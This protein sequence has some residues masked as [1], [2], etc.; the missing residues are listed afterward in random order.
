[1][2]S[3]GHLIP[4]HRAVS[5]DSNAAGFNEQGTIVATAPS[6]A[7][8]LS[9]MLSD[10]MYSTGGCDKFKF[11][12]IVSRMPTQQIEA[13]LIASKRRS[14]HEIHQGYFSRINSTLSSSYGDLGTSSLSMSN[15]SRYPTTAMM[16]NSPPLMAAPTLFESTM[17]KISSYVRDFEAGK[18]FEFE[19]PG[20]PADP[21]QQEP[22]ER[23]SFGHA[24]SLS[25]ASDLTFLDAVHIFL[26][27]ACIEVFAATEDDITAQGRGS[28]PTK[29]GQVG[30]R[31]IHC[32]DIH[33]QDLAK[34]AV[35][36][37]SKCDT[38]F[39]S[40]RNYRRLHLEVCP[41]IPDEM[42]VKYR[43]L[44]QIQDDISLPLKKP[45]R[46]IKAY[47]AEAA[48][49][50]GLVDTPDGLAFSGSQP[51]NDRTGAPSQRLAALIR[52]AESPR[53]FAEFQRAHSHQGKDEA[54]E[55][56]KFEHVASAAT[57]RVIVDARKEPST[58]VR[59][60]DFPT[61]ADAEFLIFHQLTA[62]RPTAASSSASLEGINDAK[63][64]SFSGLCCKHCARV[65]YD[66]VEMTRRDRNGMYFP[67]SVEWLNHSSFSQTI[68]HHLMGCPK[69]PTE[70][71]NALDE[72]KHLAAKHGVTTKR[73]SKKRFFNNIWTRMEKYYE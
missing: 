55:R 72:L 40:V 37:P 27:S 35:C 46:M 52:A 23:P 15:G 1:M 41:C 17:P 59:P 9:A 54:L 13:L 2:N 32:K 31:C 36:F 18:G 28:R 62:C 65:N 71:K 45:N 14:M 6:S 3:F 4:S 10:M 67:S 26:R 8:T 68:L 30:L 66:G 50:L 56:K 16:M 21:P 48:S 19:Y 12:D 39:E 24:T 43:Y 49:E 7:P 5:D 70:I 11:K 22:T 42:K 57:R 20:R 38:I 25:I 60:H 64:H 58:F 34:Q 44:I 53:K 47:Y 29:V 73:G 51:P 69:V 61:I 63:H 33:R